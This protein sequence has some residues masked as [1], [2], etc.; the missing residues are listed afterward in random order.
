VVVDGQVSMTSRGEGVL[1]R[2]W[3]T[4][5]RAEQALLAGFTSDEISLL[6]KQL[7]RIQE[8]SQLLMSGHE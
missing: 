2:L 7:R 6:M 8:Q 5:E 1:A 4:V 3:P